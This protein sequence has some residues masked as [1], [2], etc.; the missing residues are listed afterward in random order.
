MPARIVAANKYSTPCSST[1][2]TTT[3]L[4]IVNA[5]GDSNQSSTPTV[6]GQARGQANRISPNWQPDADILAHIRQHNIPE[7]FAYQQLGEFITYWRDRDQVA[8]SWGAKF[9]KHVLQAWRDRESFDARR[10]RQE[11]ERQQRS[12]TLPENWQPRADIIA[13]LTADGVPQTFIGQCQSRFVLYQQKQGKRSDNW[14]M[15]FYSW[16]KDDWQKRETPYLAPKQN[17]AMTSDWQPEGH[18][19]E[20]LKGLGIP[21]DFIAQCLAE[22]THKWIEKGAVHSSWG[23]VFARHVSE[24][25]RIVQAGGK[26]NAE[27]T[28]LANNW[29]PS[30]DCLSFLQTQMGLN[31]EYVHQQI[32]EFVLYWR[33]RG[34][35]RHSWDKQ[36]VNHVKYTLN[37][38]QNSASQQGAG[39][40]AST[41]DRSIKQDL[42]DLSWAD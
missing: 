19:L 22:F 8:H 1:S 14:D 5:S 35:V 20:L 25:W 38:G 24:H 32:P 28:L 15:A 10:Q 36:F 18:T 41:R 16:V 42:T 31:P 29:Q 34:E 30:A 21:R 12:A 39:Q 2:G 40:S 11:R 33:G 4:P 7:D 26:R 17:S 3:S 37:Q 27:P 6:S 23:D 13:Q 9:I